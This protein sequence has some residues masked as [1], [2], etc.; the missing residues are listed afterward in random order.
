MAEC[1]RCYIV[2]R[3]SRF[4]E[5][6]KKSEFL[7]TELI[8]G[9][10]LNLHRDLRWVAKRTRKFLCKYTEVAKKKHFKAD[11]PLLDWLIIS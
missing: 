8:T 10:E 2:T 7:S 9:V 4:N 3:P 5:K 11:Y 1:C 6:V